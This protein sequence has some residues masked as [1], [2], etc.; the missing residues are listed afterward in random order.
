MLW[1]PSVVMASGDLLPCGTRSCAHVEAVLA[2]VEPSDE[3]GVELRKIF[4]TRV[5]A[6]C[7]AFHLATSGQRLL[8]RGAREDKLAEI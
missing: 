3:G 6:V 8:E 1:G 4:Q 5:S 2:W 7:C